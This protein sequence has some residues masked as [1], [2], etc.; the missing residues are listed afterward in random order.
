[1]KNLSKI[2]EQ[3]AE[4]STAHTMTRAEQMLAV[5]LFEKRFGHVELIPDE[6]SIWLANFLTYKQKSNLCGL[7]WLTSYVWGFAR[8]RGVNTAELMRYMTT[9]LTARV[10]TPADYRL[11][12]LCVFLWD[13]SDR[14][15]WSTAQTFDYMR[16]AFDTNDRV[17]DQGTVKP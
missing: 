7:Y 8:K 14:C 5:E 1:M 4:Q 15:K 12:A 13:W 10:R 11:D 17:A 6:L 2:L 9:V 3:Q 16:T